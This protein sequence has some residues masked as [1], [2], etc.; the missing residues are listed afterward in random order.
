MHTH[1]RTQAECYEVVKWQ[2]DFCVSTCLIMPLT[3]VN[4]YAQVDASER[5]D[6]GD[7]NYIN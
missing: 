7:S 1:T 4:G 2:D 6:R 5:V 3:S